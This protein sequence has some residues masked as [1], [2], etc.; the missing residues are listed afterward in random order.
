MAD[1]QN[2][3]DKNLKEEIKKYGYHQFKWAKTEQ[4]IRSL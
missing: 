2:K 3:Q 1:K 4:I